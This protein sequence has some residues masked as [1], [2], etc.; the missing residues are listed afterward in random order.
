LNVTRAIDYIQKFTAAKRKHLDQVFG[1][2]Q[3]YLDTLATHPHYQLRGAGTQL[4]NA[5]IGRGRKDHV[6]VTVIAEPTA[7]TFYVHLGFTSVVNISITSV[8]ND[9]I[10]RYVV[11]AY[12]FE[13][14]SLRH[15][16]IHWS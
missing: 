14:E 10:F 8:D 6:N 15:G 11:M 13:G 5:G 3:L 7:E 16:S 2:D 12:D 4:V 9:Q 1:T